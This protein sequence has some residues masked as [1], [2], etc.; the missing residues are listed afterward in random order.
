MF[1]GFL[2]IQYG[3]KTHA[4]SSKSNVGRKHGRFSKSNMGRR[5]TLTRKAAR[6]GKLKSVEKGQTVYRQYSQIY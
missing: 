6:E 5:H 3:K 1:L 2:K 4:S